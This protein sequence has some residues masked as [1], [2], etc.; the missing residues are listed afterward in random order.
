MILTRTGEN[1]NFLFKKM[2]V[3]LFRTIFDVKEIKF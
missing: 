3:Y 2:W 1:K